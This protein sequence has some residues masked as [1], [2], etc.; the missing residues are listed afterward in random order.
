LGQLAL[1]GQDLGSYQ[2]FWDRS[3]KVDAIRAIADQD[4]DESFAARRAGLEEDV[5]I[6]L[7]TN[8]TGPDTTERNAGMLLDPRLLVASL[9]GCLAF[10]RHPSRDGTSCDAGR[11]IAVVGGRRGS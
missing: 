7:P 10:A 1:Q 5:E 3:A 9:V 8:L 4:S 11:A 2:A 6:L